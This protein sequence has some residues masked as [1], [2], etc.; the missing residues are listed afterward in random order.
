MCIFRHTVIAQHID[1]SIR[2][3][4]WASHAALVVKNPPANAG[5]VRYAG[6]ILGL[7]RSPGG[8]YGN[9]VQYSWLENLMDRGAWWVT[10]HR[11]TESQI[12]LKRQDAHTQSTV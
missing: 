6:L 3:T 1:Y 7:G 4:E 11:V 12:L 8:G 10:V 5:D 2:N 9:L